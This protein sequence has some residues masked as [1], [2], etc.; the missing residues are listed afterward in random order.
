MFNFP[1][2]LP[3]FYNPEKD[4]VESFKTISERVKNSENNDQQ[5]RAIMNQVATQVRQ[6][7]NRS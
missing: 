2:Q 6:G 4:L 5:F 3:D 1:M 7:M